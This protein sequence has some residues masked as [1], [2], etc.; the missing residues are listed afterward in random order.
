MTAIEDKTRFCEAA[1]L[2]AETDTALRPIILAVGE[3]DK[4]KRSGRAL[5]QD[6]QIVLA[7][8][9]DISPELLQTLNPDVVLSPLLCPAF[10]CLDL[11]QA[12][13]RSGFRGRYRIIA[14]ALPDPAVII[15]EIEMLCPGLDF[16]FIF[17][18][19]G[20]GRRLN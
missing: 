17:T 14:P 11:A 4:W 7:E 19:D 20:L 3:V 5:P 18:T 2:R 15:S 10:D 12:L 16:S 9:H 8:F 1:G 13:T 6:S